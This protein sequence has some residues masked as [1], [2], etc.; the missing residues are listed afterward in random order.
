M[1]LRVGVKLDVRGLSQASRTLGEMIVST[2]GH[3]ALDFARKRTRRRS[4]ALAASWALT[5]TPRTASITSPLKY[6]AAYE[7]GSS[8]HWIAAKNAKYLAFRWPRAGGKQPKFFKRVY[9]PGTEGKRVLDT[10]FRAAIY[11]TSLYGVERRRLAQF[12]N[13]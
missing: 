11:T 1:R 4:G 7:G 5:T 13:A 9:H 12:S 10:S 8:P 2:I 6:A 3:K